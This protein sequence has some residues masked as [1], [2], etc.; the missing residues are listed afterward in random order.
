[1]GYHVSILRKEQGGLRPITRSEVENIST[2]DFTVQVVDSNVGECG[3][4]FFVGGQECLWLTLQ[5]G[6]L[7]TSNPTSQEMELMLDVAKRLN[8]RVRGDEFETYTTLGDTYI[9][10][11]D[12]DEI[13]KADELVRVLERR[14]RRN[15][16]LL[17]VFI[18]GFF[19]IMG[20]FVAYFS[21]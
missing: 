11:D 19:I 21:S 13:K 3:F 8:A 7:W 17:H 20:L 15:Q 9:H 2:L 12:K 1:M 10:P 16:I 4:L 14:M 6:E 5:D 18:F